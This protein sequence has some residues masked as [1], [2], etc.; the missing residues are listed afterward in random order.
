MPFVAEI[1]PESASRPILS[2][3]AERLDLLDDDTL[4]KLLGFLHLL[5]AE[6]AAY[7]VWAALQ[8]RDASRIEV[9]ITAQACLRATGTAGGCRAGPRKAASAR[10]RLA[11]EV[12]GAGVSNRR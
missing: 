5:G 6:G 8:A 11:G 9:T 3:I 12:R 7:F 2:A 4:E 10:R 1:A